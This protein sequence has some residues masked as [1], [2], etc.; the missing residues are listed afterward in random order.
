MT[1]SIQTTRNN[2]HP[3]SY[4]SSNPDI[5]KKSLEKMDRLTV[6]ILDTTTEQ[7]RLNF[8]IKTL[9]PYNEF[10]SENKQNIHIAPMAQTTPQT[11]WNWR[12]GV[13]KPGALGRLYGFARN[14]FESE[15]A[16]A[17]AFGD[18]VGCDFLAEAGIDPKVLK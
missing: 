18:A 7:E 4:D 10:P 8:Y 11:I 2:V 15:L 5:H 13:T 16:M 12:A 17:A 3:S 1:L 6:L 14:R 9:A